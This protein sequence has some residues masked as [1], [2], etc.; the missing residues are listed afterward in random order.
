MRFVSTESPIMS[1]LQKKVVLRFFFFSHSTDTECMVSNMHHLRTCILCPQN[2]Y[3]SCLETDTIPVSEV[4]EVSLCNSTKNCSKMNS[5]LISNNFYIIFTRFLHHVAYFLHP[6]MQT[7]AKAPEIK[8]I[9][10]ST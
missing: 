10:I 4:R 9:L 5:N 7:N 2:S 6:K 1:F 8:N 3:F